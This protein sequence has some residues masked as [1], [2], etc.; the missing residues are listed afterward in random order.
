[1]KHHVSDRLHVCYTRVCTGDKRDLVPPAP[2]LTRYK[3]EVAMKSA[4]NKKK[5]ADPR[6]P[7]ERRSSE[8]NLLSTTSLC[9]RLNTLHVSCFGHPLNGYSPT[10]KVSGLNLYS[11][12]TKKNTLVFGLNLG[13]DIIRFLLELVKCHIISIIQEIQLYLTTFTYLYV[14]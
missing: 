5:V 9:V 14:L 4:S 1:L 2:S 12:Q 8:I 3:K 11:K 7:D 10:L 6:L 13:N